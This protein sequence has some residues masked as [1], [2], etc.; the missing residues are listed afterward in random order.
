MRF[1]ELPP[2]PTVAQVQELTQLGRSQVYALVRQWV[3]TGG[4][5]GLPSVRFGRLLRIPL[6]AL[7]RLS[8]IEDPQGG[9]HAA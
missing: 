8:L 2:F 7:V 3:R 5:E 1:E 9:G 4:R 6:A